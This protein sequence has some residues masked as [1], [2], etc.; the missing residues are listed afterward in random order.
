MRSRWEGIHK[1]LLR[2][3]GGLNA[4]KQFAR[5]RTR[6][7]M[8]ETFADPM[9]LVG[10]LSQP[11]GDL[12]E[13]DRIIWL[14]IDE[15]RRGEAPSLAQAILFLGLWR[16]LDA[17]FVRRSALFRQ[18][19]ADLDAELVDG[20]IEQLGR[21]DPARVKR[22]AAT[23]VRNTERDVVVSRTHELARSARAVVVTPDVALA[24]PIEP[25]ASPFNQHPDQTDEAAVGAIALWLERVTGPDAYLVVDVV[26][27][28][29]DRAALASA[30]GISR[31]ALNKR[32]ER[33]LARA[34]RVLE[35]DAMSP[36]RISV[37]LVT[38]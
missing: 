3:A 32:V 27:R 7:S 20:F 28:G 18:R 11:E 21:L 13:K 17:I 5:W 23:L 12:D 34:R 14:L 6:N 4:A 30:R 38:A 9:S 16:A 26:L 22:V 29:R 33:A 10:Y 2:S 36:A 1:G 8:L 35:V 37:A 15:A 24:P 19:G 31:K 25:E